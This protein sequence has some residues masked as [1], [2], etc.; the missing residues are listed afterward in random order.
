MVDT[1][2]L[3]GVKLASLVALDLASLGASI[4]KMYFCHWE[5]VGVSKSYWTRIPEWPNPRVYWNQCSGRQVHL[6]APGPAIQKP[7]CTREGW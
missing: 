3:V 4:G 2:L 6:G 5:L 1:A 7:G